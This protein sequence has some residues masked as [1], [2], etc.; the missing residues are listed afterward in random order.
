MHHGG[1]SAPRKNLVRCAAVRQRG[2]AALASDT[3]AWVLVKVS[4]NRAI[5]SEHAVTMRLPSG[6]NAA[7]FTSYEWHLSTPIDLPLSASHTRAVQPL[8]A[9]PRRLPPRRK[10]ALL[11][12]SSGPVSGSPIGLPV[13]AS[14]TRAVVSVDAVTMRLPSGLNAALITPSAW[15]LSGSPIGL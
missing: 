6:L 12:G 1:G 13:S 15:P 5:P 8:G 10:A 3:N 11:T 4:H 14:H 9:V 7:L 2:A